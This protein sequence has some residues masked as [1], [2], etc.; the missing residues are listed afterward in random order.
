MEKEFTYKFQD[1]LSINNMKKMLDKMGD[2]SNIQV[3]IIIYK[4]SH[5]GCEFIRIPALGGFREYKEV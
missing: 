1:W 3:N 4:P 5:F 2:Y